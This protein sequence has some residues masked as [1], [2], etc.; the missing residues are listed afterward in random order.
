MQS[1]VLQTLWMVG[2]GKEEKQPQNSPNKLYC[3]K[4][5]SRQGGSLLLSVLNLAGDQDQRPHGKLL[6]SLS[7][8]VLARPKHRELSLFLAS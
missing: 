3:G 1:W 2:E 8:R 7:Q 6:M 4:I 5:S